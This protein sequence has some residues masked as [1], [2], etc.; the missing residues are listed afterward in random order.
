MGNGIMTNYGQRSE[1][2]WIKESLE[3]IIDAGQGKKGLDII[4]NFKNHEHFNKFENINCFV[5]SHGDS[6][7]ISLA[8]EIIDKF[9]P[10]VIVVSPLV[11]SINKY[12]HTVYQILG[13]NH[14]NQNNLPDWFFD[15]KNYEY[16]SIN[17]LN[18]YSVENEFVRVEGAI[19][20][21]P[22][23]PHELN[24]QTDLVPALLDF[25]DRYLK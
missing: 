17:K 21:F 19:H 7:H 2:F 20:A 11:Y 24:G 16:H 15:E 8:K 5:I 6:D 18:E 3:Y 1:S 12:R 4:Q 25:L 23:V 10:D 13:E 22:V 9:H 14:P